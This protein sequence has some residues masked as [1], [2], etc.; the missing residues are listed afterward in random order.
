[1]LVNQTLI[2]CKKY[3]IYI[4]FLKSAKIK[5]INVVKCLPTTWR[6]FFLHDNKDQW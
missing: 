5:P 1:M 2:A 4:S 3:K 6:K